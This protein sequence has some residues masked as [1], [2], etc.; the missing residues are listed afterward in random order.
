MRVRAYI[1]LGLASFAVALAF[2]LI[3]VSWE[4]R[5]SE[6][7]VLSGWYQG[8]F[9]T[10]LC[11]ARG[12]SEGSLGLS[13]PHAHDLRPDR[14]AVLVSLPIS[15]LGGLLAIGILPENVEQLMR[16]FFGTTMFFALGWALSPLFPDRRWFGLVWVGTAFGGGMATLVAIFYGADSV[17]AVVSGARSLEQSYYWWFLD[18]FR[19]LM[20]P[21]EAIY[22]TLLFLH[23]GLLIRMQYGAATATLAVLCLCNPF[24]GIQSA[25]LHGLTLLIA[26]TRH[27]VRRST[28]LASVLVVFCF[29]FYYKYYLPLDPVIRIVQDFHTNAY[30]ETLTWKSA[31][32]GYGLAL[33]FVIAALFDP[34]WRQLLRREWLLWPVIVLGVTSLSL[35]LN[36]LFLGDYGLQPMHFTRG[37]LRTAIWVIA[38]HWLFLRSK[39]FKRDMFRNLIAVTAAGLT[40]LTLPDSL[41]FIHDQYRLPPHYSSLRWNHNQEAVLDWLREQPGSLR[42]TVHDWSLARQICALTPHRSAFGTAFNTPF[43]PQRSQQYKALLTCSEQIQRESSELTL[44][45]DVLIVPTRH[46]MKLRSGCP[47]WHEVMISPDWSV[48]QA[49]RK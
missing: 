29:V 46:S 25:A 13:Y 37:Y 17:D 41:A 1:L 16:V 8:D 4:Y 27:Q 22:H 3:L 6:S 5:I 21:L 42:V 19:N 36:T 20:Y 49:V 7:E 28:L 30:G 43:F 23:L 12:T 48:F 40:L 9:P 44:W 33:P 11:Y 2:T 14:P 18:V 15:L 31:W 32:L 38:M 26:M 39:V 10:Y 47:S 35:S 34:S 24:A 45:T